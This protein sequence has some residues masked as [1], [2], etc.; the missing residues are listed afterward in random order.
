MAHTVLDEALN[1]VVNATSDRLKPFGFSRQ[2]PILRMIDQGNCGIVEFQR[3]RRS[4]SNR[5]LFTVN[6]GVVCGE[7]LDPISH[8]LRKARIVDAHVRQRIGTFLPARPDKWW[9]ISEC[10]DLNSVTAEV[11]ELIL[12]AAVPYIQRYINTDAIAELWGSEQSPGLTNSQRV[13]LLAKL[14]AVRKGGAA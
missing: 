6:I 13:N 10:T 14:R 12:K 1:K 5:L 3:S 7:L 8:Q 2:G 11:S 4:S 9:A